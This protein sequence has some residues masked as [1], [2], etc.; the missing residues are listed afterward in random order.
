MAV[1]RDLRLKG[2]SN[3]SKVYGEGSV[4]RSDVVVVYYLRMT[5]KRVAVVVSKRFGNAVKRN[6]IRRLLLEAWSQN[7]ATLPDGYYIILPRSAILNMPEKTW[8]QQAKEFFSEWRS[9]E[10]SSHTAAVL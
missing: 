10:N 9:G 8:R 6:R 7:R 3:F 2:K 4:L 1:K 5:Q